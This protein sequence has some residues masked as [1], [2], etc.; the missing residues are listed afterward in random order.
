MH[1]LT[2]STLYGTFRSAGD[3]EDWSGPCVIIII[4][5]LQSAFSAKLRLMLIQFAFII[6]VPD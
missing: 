3:D 5:L 1:E 6:Q 4:I 2:I